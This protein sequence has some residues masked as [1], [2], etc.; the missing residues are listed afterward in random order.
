LPDPEL[1]SD[2]S[3]G[4]VAA[5]TMS[6]PVSHQATDELK[7]LQLAV[8]LGASLSATIAISVGVGIGVALFYPNYRRL[9]RKLTRYELT[10]L[11]IIAAI[12]G[13]TAVATVNVLTQWDQVKQGFVENYRA[14]FNR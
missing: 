9:G 3:G 12:A 1:T 7:Y 2:G 4:L 10:W 5:V 6:T 14:L 11:V 8:A 13:L